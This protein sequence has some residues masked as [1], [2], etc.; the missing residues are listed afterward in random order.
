[1]STPSIRSAEPRDRPLV[2]SLP[3]LR[4]G[5]CALILFAWPTFSVNVARA[6]LF[7]VPINVLSAIFIW[8]KMSFPAPADASNDGHVEVASGRSK[9]QR[10][11][12]PGAITIGIANASLLLLLDE[13]Q[14]NPDALHDPKALMSGGGW[15]VFL[16]AFMAIEATWAQEPIFPLRLMTRRSV[17]SSYCIQFLQ[18]AAQMAVRPLFQS[19]TYLR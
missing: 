6:L 9:L 15:I 4:I 5:D 10:I 12:F 13:L 19:R 2:G 18:T 17:F 3:T 11:D 1:M 14:R 16:A 8:W 7:Q